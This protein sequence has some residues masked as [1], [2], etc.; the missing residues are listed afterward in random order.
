MSTRKTIIL[1]TLLVVLTAGV[2][3]IFGNQMP[4]RMASHWDAKG[5]VNGYSDKTFALYF[6]P[7]MEIILVALFL[8]LPL[9]DPRKQNIQKFRPVYN[10]FVIFVFGFL[11][12]LHFLTLAWN[13]GWI[14]NL[15]RW[16]SP[17]YAALLFFAGV[18][19]GNAQPNWFI[20]IRTPW[21]L[22]DNQ[23][24]EKT[25]K[26][27]GTAFKVCGLISLAGVIF[28]QQATWFLLIPI[29]AVAL[30][31]FVYSYLYYRSLHQREA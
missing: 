19:I 17:A 1:I 28:P 26:I 2:S 27:G 22:S 5:V 10:L 7:G 13:L 9:I 4:D 21:T 3:F 25:H 15:M 6:V 8:A 16:M 24:W 12:Y 20:G 11:S 14:F 23:V 31:L 18:L 30:G 29:L